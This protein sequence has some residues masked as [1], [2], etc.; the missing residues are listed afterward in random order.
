MREGRG[1]SLYGG[2][3][4]D[5]APVSFLPFYR[6][7][8]VFRRAVDAPGTRCPDTELSG[9]KD[10]IALPPRPEPVLVCLVSL[11]PSSESK[12]GRTIRQ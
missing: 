12:Q 10:I 6:L 7:V 1:L 11:K 3:G 2:T 9:K 8:D 4:E 5:V